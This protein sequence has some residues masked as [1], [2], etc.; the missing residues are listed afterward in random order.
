MVRNRCQ[1]R[2][3]PTR[4]R[5][6]RPTIDAVLDAG[7]I[8]HVA[9]VD[10]GQPY[11]VP[12]L[13]ARVGDRVYIH[14]STASRAVHR[15]GSGVPACLTVS[16]IDGLVLARSVFDHSANYRSVMLLGTFMRIDDPQE[17]LVALEAFSDALVPGRWSEVRPPSAREVKASVIL[18][19]PIAEA[20]AKVRTG[21][22]SDGDSPDAAAGIWA[23]VIPV[24]TTFGAPC[25]APELGAVPPP[26][27]VSRLLRARR[28]SDRRRSTD[29]RGR[30]R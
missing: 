15:L 11:A 27:S 4:G 23:G 28:R 25:A 17:K 9:F 2:R 12:M 22:P 5:Y 16:M 10:H 24:E 6:D 7:L 14:G 13:Y 29:P 30:G 20:A 8:A 1:V 18:A 26:P 21:P 19:L 3:Q